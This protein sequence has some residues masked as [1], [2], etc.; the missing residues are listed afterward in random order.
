MSPTDPNDPTTERLHPQ[1]PHE[2]P[3]ETGSEPNPLLDAERTDPELE[4]LLRDDPHLLDEIAKLQKLEFGYDDKVLQHDL[5]LTE[6]ELQHLAEGGLVHDLS[7]REHLKS[8]HTCQTSLQQYRDLFELLNDPTTADEEQLPTQFGAAVL[9]KVRKIRRAERRRRSPIIPV[10]AVL[11]A[12]ASAVGYLGIAAGGA[13]VW[14]VLER[15]ST[16]LATRLGW[17]LSSMP[18]G[19]WAA[20]V[21]AVYFLIDLLIQRQ[22]EKARK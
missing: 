20:V 15:G 10:T 5:H 14:E 19:L 18:T 1:G 3:P 2:R 21:L 13:T 17:T 12:L 4:A 9:S 16:D 6:D 11:V 22:T 7:V 8:C